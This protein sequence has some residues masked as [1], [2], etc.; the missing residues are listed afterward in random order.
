M[1]IEYVC[2]K[3][4]GANVASDATA[5]WD[6]KTQAWIIVGHYDSSEC[7]D[8]AEERALIPREIA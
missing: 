2:E 1:A 3:C 7:L 8:Y 4:G 5:V 6:A